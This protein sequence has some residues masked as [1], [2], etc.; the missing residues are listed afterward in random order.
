MNPFRIPESVPACPAGRL[1]CLEN[2]KTTPSCAFT[3]GGKKAI[4][5]LLPRRLGVV[6][7]FAEIYEESCTRQIAFLPAHFSRCP[8]EADELYVAPVSFPAGLYFFRLRV[9]CAHGML[10]GYRRGQEIFLTTREQGDLFRFSF[11]E[12]SYAPP[13]MWYGGILYHIFVD[14]FC[15]GGDVP[16]RD[17]AVVEQN[18]EEGIPEYPAY[19]GAPLKNNTF[20]G[21]TLYGIAE[22]MDY[23]QS[24]GV[25][26]LYLSPVFDSP[27]NH[28]YDTGDYSRVDP[29]FGGEEGLRCLL[30]AAQKRGIGVILDGVFNHTG[31]DSL[32]FNRYGR[33]PG[34]GAYQSPSSPYYSWY[35][36]QQFPER[37]TC[38]WGI[39]ILPRIRTDAPGFADFIA[40]PGGIV[41][42]YAKMGV[43]GFRLDVADELSDGFIAAIKAALNRVNPHSLLY[44]EVWEDASCKIAYGKRKQYYLGR[45]LDGVMNYPLRTGLIRY[46]RDGE[47]GELL[48]ALTDIIYNAPARIRNM[49]MNLLGTHDTERILTALGGQSA[50]GHSNAELRQM[51]MSAQEREIGLCRLKMAYTVL[52]TL[53]G[54]PAIYY[55]DEAGLEGYSDPFN[56]MPYPWGRQEDTLLSH[57]RETGRIRRE[58]PVYATG[59]YRLLHLSRDMLCFVRWEGRVALFTFVNRAPA[60]R[61]L[62]FSSVATE[63]YTGERRRDFT[64]S[65][66]TARVFRGKHGMT[67]QIGE[68]LP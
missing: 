12:F 64:V 22:K 34:V 55:G 50:R 49:Q 68:D 6:S 66:W 13:A 58:N 14:R 24:L 21:G 36:F 43:A 20:Y 8:T 42:T 54:I 52:A 31:D 18:W 30:S 25:T 35:E 27:S 41:E 5:I 47:T 53:P 26:L 9:C 61:R 11:S 19:P 56:R 4:Q 51:R 40:G 46:F 44:G 2:G 37:Y 57:Y 48:Y 28:K 38:W 10:Y 60:P 65:P 3:A 17:G 29:M 59:D 1:S 45:E 63:L 23:L 39:D 67:L 16:V 62:R 32:Y 33:Y 15:R 7:V